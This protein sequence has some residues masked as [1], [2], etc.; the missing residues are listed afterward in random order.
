MDYCNKGQIMI[1]AKMATNREEE[2][3]P[4]AEEE[5]QYNSPNAA[6]HEEAVRRLEAEEEKS[7]I[8][9]E[10]QQ[11]NGHHAVPGH[12]DG[13]SSKQKVERVEED[14]NVPPKNQFHVHFICFLVLS[15]TYF[16]ALSLV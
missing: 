13:E 5:E 14:I 16:V 12:C 1:S 2:E 9:S 11:K 4:E 15:F 6:R 3:N 10:I 7:R 8:L